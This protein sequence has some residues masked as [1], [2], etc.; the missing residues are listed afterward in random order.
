VKWSREA[1]V[2]DLA[3]NGIELGRGRGGDE[4][5]LEGLIDGLRSDP[6][7]RS[8]SVIAS[9]SYVPK[10]PRESYVRSSHYR[11]IP[12]L[13]WEQNL[14]LRR[15]SYDWYASTYFLPPIAPKRSAVFVHDVSF[16]ALPRAF[17]PSVRW[18]MR[19]LVG[20]AMR[21]ARI[22]FVLSHFVASEVRRFYAGLPAQR[23]QVLY[24]G[25]D[26]VYTP[27]CQPVDA[28]VLRRHGLERGY[29]LSVSSLHPR[30]NMTG[31]LRAYELAHA[32]VSLPPLVLVGQQYWG[33]SALASQVARANA[34]LLGYV[35]KADL[36]ALYRASAMFVYPS[37]YEGF[38]LPPLEAMACGVPVVCGLNSSLPE[39]VGDAGLLVNV[40]QPSAIADAI[41]TLLRDADLRSELA[42]RGLKRSASFNWAATARGFVDA[43]L[44]TNPSTARR[45]FT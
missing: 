15:L 9:N 6:R 36:P 11:R 10:A 14:A 22:V 37:L 27:E 30:K 43:L 21:R 35:P 26:R 24:P 39:A 17:P 33:N 20:S 4:S 28:D 12:Y 41:A 8:L 45:I 1:R 13:L 7:V 34:R 19:G 16:R 29:V 40:S 23:V 32:A 18:Y 38:G 25:C 42:R 31:L 2:L 44:Q 5:Y 3:I